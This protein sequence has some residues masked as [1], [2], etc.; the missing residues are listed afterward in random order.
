[1]SRLKSWRP[2]L[3]RRRTLSRL[4]A[5]SRLGGIMLYCGRNRI[6]FTNTIDQRFDLC[7][8]DSAP[9]FRSVL[10]PSL[11]KAPI[12]RKKKVSHHEEGHDHTAN[13]DAPA[14]KDKKTDH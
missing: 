14:D 1:M 3:S 12:E 5:N 6:V 2:F 9:D 7:I 10:F 11:Y 4:G 8:G 13:K